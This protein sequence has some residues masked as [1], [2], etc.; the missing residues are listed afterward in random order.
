M[1]SAPPAIFSADA[2]RGALIRA[3]DSVNETHGLGIAL[4]EDMR[5][6]RIRH[7]GG[8]GATVVFEL[9]ERRATPGPRHVPV[10]PNR[11]SD[12]SAASEWMGLGLN[13]GGAVLAWIGVVGT[14]ALAPVTGGASGVATALLWGGALASTGQCMAS[15]YRNANVY[16]G[17]QDINDALDHNS[18]YVWTMRA[19]DGVGLLGA[20]GALK[21]VKA[22]NAALHSA[23]VEWRTASGALSRPLRR[24]LTTALELEGAKRVATHEINRFVRQKLLDATGGVIGLI[25]SSTSGII[26][27]VAVWITE[28]AQ[29]Q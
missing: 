7:Q 18:S 14:A 17:R 4:I 6:T 3:V 5:L 27:E 19:A 29:A 20:G 2:Q 16:R 23:G 24:R 22:A 1:A 8:S 26:K 11:S 12:S 15:S 28:E 10:V 9:R 13:C 25:G 21:E